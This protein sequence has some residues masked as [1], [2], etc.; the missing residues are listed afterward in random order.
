MRPEG[1]MVRD[2]LLSSTGSC[3]YGK[4]IRTV[5]GQLMHSTEIY[6]FL[7]LPIH[8]LIM[9]ILYILLFF[10]INFFW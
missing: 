7:I 2:T 1:W 6:T 3:N 8:M 5:S 9:D 4:S 10:F